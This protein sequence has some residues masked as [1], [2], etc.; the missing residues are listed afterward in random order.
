MKNGKNTIIGFLVAAI[1]VMSVGYALLSQQVTINGVAEVSSTWSVGITGI[2]EGIATG[3]ALNK[4]PSTYTG[5]TAAF[6]VSLSAPGDSMTYDITV[7]NNGSIDAILSAISV[8][9]EEGG[10]DAINYEVTGVT[11]GTTTLS[12]GTTNTITVKVEWDKTA[13]G[14]PT[15]LSKTLTVTLNYVQA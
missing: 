8:T 15:V 10:S 14:V 7:T 12:A 11:A 9:P 6:D 5:T 1:M 4:T 13:I 3:G 2:T